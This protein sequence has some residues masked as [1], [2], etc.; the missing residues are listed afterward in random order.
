M[1]NFKYCILIIISF[2]IWITSTS[3]L[4][5]AKND[6]VTDN[7]ILEHDFYDLEFE[8]IDGKI[9]SLSNF[10]GNMF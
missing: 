2:S 1:K 5:D 8:S 9:I 6:L 4:A 7:S 3:F 10:K